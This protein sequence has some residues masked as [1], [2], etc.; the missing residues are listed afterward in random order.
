DRYEIEVFDD[1]LDRLSTTARPIVLVIEDIHWADEGTLDFIRFIGRRISRT[2]TL[3]VCSYRDDE[4]G[5]DHSL[6]PVLGQLIPLA[7][8]IRIAIPSL[9][10]HA[11][12]ELARGEQ[13]D[14]IALH[15][16]SGGNAFFVTEVL[17]SGTDIP[18]TVQDAVIARVSRLTPDARRAVEA[19]S[20]A[21]RMLEIEKTRALVGASFASVDQ[22][23][24]SGVLLGDGINLRFRHELARA[25]IE[26]SLPPGRRLEMH[27]RMIGLLLEDDYRDIA[28]LAHHAIRAQSPELIVE[29]APEAADRAV[30][31]G[32][33]REATAF[34]RAALEFPNEL[35]EDMTADLRVKLATELRSLAQPV[36]AE[37][38][39]RQAIEHYRVADKPEQLADAL[40]LLQ[41]ALWNQRRF[42][43]GWEA[44]DEAIEIL[45]PLGPTEA[46]AMS[47]Y[48]IAHHHMLARHAGPAF[49]AVR[50]AGEIAE[51]VGSTRATWLAE[52]MTGCTHIVAGD[53][54]LGTQ[55]LQQSVADAEQLDDQHLIASGLGML[56]SG[57]GEARLYDV[58]IPA[59]LRGVDQGLAT[60][61]DYNVAYCRSWLARVA[62]EQGRWDD[63]VEFA[64]LVARTTEHGHSIAVLTANS[65]LGR[66][67]VRRGDPG[68]VDLIT[69]MLEIGREHE[70]QHAWNA[71]CGY[72]EYHWLRGT[73]EQAIDELAP[74]YQRALETDSEWAR[75]ELG[76]WMWKL[77]AI[78]EPPEGAAEPFGFLISGDWHG[79]AEMWRRIG[80]PYEVALA[81]AQGDEPAKLDSLEIF[82]SLGARPI[83]DR[84]RSELKRAG[85][86]SIPRGPSKSTRENPEGLTNRQMEVLDL[87]RDGLSNAEIAHELFISK[88]T[89]EHHVSAIFTKLGVDTRTKAIATISATN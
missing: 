58:S 84:L 18:A 6:R 80:C 59:L 87:M 4:V 37:I 77:G 68:G 34:Y 29:F 63:A 17:A 79:A 5:A 83:G 55:L 22:A 23:V 50:R 62:F 82:D 54:S 42:A 72:S 44:M 15:D 86:G 10:Q 35:G 45:Q 20:I 88:K 33:R 56:G 89:V 30:V 66:V 31:Q 81:L 43:E 12:S 67:R 60:D 70:L 52:M 69:E 11:V 16:V 13:V 26:D 32:A 47:W 7:S 2:K 49:D 71:I 78:K 85:V 46:L 24:G 74:A 28:R 8:T 64:E 39:L 65:A 73:P 51:T 21:P 9:S 25:A 61:E 75:G 14:P 76:F 19:V 3:F 41:G 57:G 1:V 40:G 48:R 36:E 27:R 53:P 38:E